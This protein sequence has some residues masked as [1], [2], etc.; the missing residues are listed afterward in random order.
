MVFSLAVTNKTIFSCSYFY[1]LII[2][3][4]FLMSAVITKNFIVAAELLITTGIP[5]KEAKTEI[6]TNLVTVEA[7]S[8]FSII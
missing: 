7:K 4:Y 8:M 3:L 5:I 1:F 6:E 2:D